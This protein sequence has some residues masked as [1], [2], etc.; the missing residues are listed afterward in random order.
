MDQE[1]Q[2]KFPT[3]I[4]DLRRSV[5]AKLE[6]TREQEEAI[7]KLEQIYSGIVE[8]GTITVDKSHTGQGVMGVEIRAWVDSLEEEPVEQ[9][10]KWGASATWDNG[11]EKYKVVHEFSMELERVN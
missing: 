3:A 2:A 4:Q 8:D 1:Y 10:L 9:L 11:E 6:H 7:T 5:Q